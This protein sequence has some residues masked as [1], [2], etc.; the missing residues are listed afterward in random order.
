MVSGSYKY[1]FS[2]SVSVS[3]WT[4]KSYVI[5]HKCPKKGGCKGK[6]TSKEKCQTGEDYT[7]CGDKCA[8]AC[9]NL[10]MTDNCP[11]SCEP[12]CFCKQ[13]FYRNNQGDCVPAPKC[14][15][16]NKRK[17]LT[18]TTTRKPKKESTTTRPPDKPKP[19]YTPT[20]TTTQKPVRNVSDSECPVGE[21]WTKC[22]SHCQELCE[23]SYNEQAKAKCPSNMNCMEGCFC[24]DGFYRY[25]YLTS[26]YSVDNKF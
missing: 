9:R 21:K 5:K 3:L 14:P 7:T 23:N 12:G 17:Y 19:T 25:S 22:G 2:M 26:I 8:E 13:N 20:S 16:Y 6:L 24:K 10:F 1:S 15:E 18:S 11:L 4:K